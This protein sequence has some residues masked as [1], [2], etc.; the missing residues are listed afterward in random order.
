MSYFLFNFLKRIFKLTLFLPAIE[1]Y[2][3]RIIPFVLMYLPFFTQYNDDINLCC[4]L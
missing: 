3:N 2:I 1:K 4:C